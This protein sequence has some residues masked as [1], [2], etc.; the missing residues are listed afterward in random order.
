MSNTV[1]AAA[2]GLP[3][4][5][6]FLLCTMVTAPVALAPALR[7]LSTASSFDPVAYIAAMRGIGMTMD[8]CHSLQSYFLGRGSGGFNDRFFAVSERFTEAYRADPRATEKVY[9]ELC[10]EGARHD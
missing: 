2:N 7:G 9:L 4:S 6:R 5:R 3:V 10:A 1:P 8:P